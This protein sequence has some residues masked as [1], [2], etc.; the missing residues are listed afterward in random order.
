MASK[1]TT[2]QANHNGKQNKKKKES[3]KNDGNIFNYSDFPL[4]QSSR[5]TMNNDNDDLLY[6]YYN[7]D[8]NKASKGG[9]QNKNSLPYSVA[10]LAGSSSVPYRNRGAYRHLSSATSELVFR[11]ANSTQRAMKELA[12]RKYEATQRK[13][14]IVLLLLLVIIG[15]SIYYV[16]DVNYNLGVILQNEKNDGTVQEKASSSSE[17][18]LLGIMSTNRG[19]G[20]GDGND[21]NDGNEENDENQEQSIDEPQEEVI[22][23]G[24]EFLQP[25]RY[26]ADLTTSPRESDSNFFF[27]IPRS[28]GQTIKDIIGKCLKKTLASEVGV[29]DGHGQDETL[30]VI[31]I[32]GA[33]YVNVD[34]TSIDGLHRAAAMGLA[35]AGY[36]DVIAS[37]YFGEVGMLFDLHHKGRAFVLLRDPIVRAVSMYYYKTQGDNP[38]I[39][40]SVS[41]EDYA[42]GNGIENSKLY[43]LSLMNNTR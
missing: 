28:G 18:E 38:S 8:N 25:Y 32:D 14:A 15:T 20:Q 13:K 40:P 29:R 39:D 33:K 7:M 17:A 19:S 3:K 24:K 41:I 23:S 10:A 16:T 26:F 21:G 12:Q 2:I 31:E 5:E 34:T 9:S 6:S 1:D 27:H 35:S 22:E 42:Q 37:S 30:Q 43:I 36:S 4:P 11:S